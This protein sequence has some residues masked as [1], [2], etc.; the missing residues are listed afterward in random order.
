M[1]DLYSKKIRMSAVRNMMDSLLIILPSTVVLGYFYN[2]PGA[3]N[4]YYHML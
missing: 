2:A 4:A 1:S 3:N